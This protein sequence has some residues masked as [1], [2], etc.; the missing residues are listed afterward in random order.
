MSKIKEFTD[1]QNQWLTG[2]LE[3]A[4]FG[5]LCHG[6]WCGSWA[7]RWCQSLVRSHKGKNNELRVIEG[8]RL[9]KVQ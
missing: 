3:W 6:I 7:G 1:L 8:V 9:T 5:E 2:W 4:R